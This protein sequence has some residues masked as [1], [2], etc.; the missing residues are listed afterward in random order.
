M[1]RVDSSPAGG[2]SPATTQTAGMLLHS[3]Y[4][5]GYPFDISPENSSWKYASALESAAPFLYKERVIP[6]QD[7]DPF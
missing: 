2:F 6:N 5:C 1:P 3:C 4:F 7:R